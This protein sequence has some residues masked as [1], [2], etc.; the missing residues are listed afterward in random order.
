MRTK[1]FATRHERSH[2]R[3]QVSAAG[4]WSCAILAFVVLGGCGT[5]PQPPGAYLESGL[6]RLRQ[7]EVELKL[8]PPL[9]QVPG[10][11]GRTIWIYRY[12][13]VRTVGPASIEELWCY[14]DA[15]TFGRD[16][17]LTHWNRQ[18]CQQ[19]RQIP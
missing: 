1:I 15:L 16:K 19:S 9:M 10:D 14:E 5:R 2:P 17:I 7:N 4:P 13:G 18:D 3:R 8:G 11:H 6:G 12:A